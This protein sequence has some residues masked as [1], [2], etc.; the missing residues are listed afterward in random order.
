MKQSI[1][2]SALLSMI[3]LA[4]CGSSEKKSQE[5]LNEE[6]R[7][8]LKDKKPLSVVQNLIKEGADVNA[9][10]EVPFSSQPD[11]N[12][13]GFVTPL[14]FPVANGTGKDLSI[15]KELVDNGADASIVFDDG[16]TLLHMAVLTER[17]GDIIRYLAQ[18]GAPV[19]AQNAFQQ[20][21]LFQAAYNENADQI[22]ALIEVGA[23]PKIKDADGKTIF[24]MIET[25]QKNGSRDA[26]QNALS[27]K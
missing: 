13:M 18:A 24:E 22:A 9:R 1:V 16:S 3:V 20:T 12:K 11:G 25:Y 26:L 5:Q 4:G 6:L 15:I 8:A 10:F 14:S 2:V 27:A 17:D 23:D 21:P 7:I 19:N